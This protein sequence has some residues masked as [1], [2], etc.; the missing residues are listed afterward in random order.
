V[1]ADAANLVRMINQIARFFDTQPG[2]A[3]AET[4]NHIRSFWA[5]SMLRELAALMPAGNERLS[6]TAH[7]A[8]LRL[9]DALG[10]PA[11]SG[12]HAQAAVSSER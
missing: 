4:L 2:D 7:A 10:V 8:A 1:N 9:K 3:A 12:D 6:P 5:P 11:S